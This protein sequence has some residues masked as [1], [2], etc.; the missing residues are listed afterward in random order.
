MSTEKK[1]EEKLKSQ[2]SSKQKDFTGTKNNST[3]LKIWKSSTQLS[4]NNNNG[5]PSY[6]DY[7]N[8][9]YI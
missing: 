4:K 1:N 7:E 3:D 5:Q 9:F 8:Y 6:A 2:G